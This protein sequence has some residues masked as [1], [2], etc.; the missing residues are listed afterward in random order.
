MT[1]P[2]TEITPIDPQAKSGLSMPDARVAPETV[3]HGLATTSAKIRALA[4]AGYDRTEISKLL[5]IVYQHVRKVM[6][7][8]GITG[9]LRRQVAAER[10]P[11]LVDAEPA[12][13]E[14]ASW[15]VLLRAGFQ[16]LGE[17]TK[18]PESAIQLDAKAPAAP[19]VYAFVV[20]D[21]VAYVGLT[22]NGLRTRLDQYRRGHEG[23][24]TNARVNKLIGTTLAAG[25]R[26][27]V[28]IATPDPLE[29]NGLPVSTA[30]GL[31]AGLIQMIRP[32]WNIMGAA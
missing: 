22:N 32:A 29:W 23:Q 11:V 4:E 14:A 18:D 12:P 17:W 13:R 16:F 15:E 28:L 7:D 9:G 6:L 25:R 2:K 27:K 19:G 8:A 10:E 24:K 26:V 20:D 5:G 21:A 1:A 30:G 3:T 31:E